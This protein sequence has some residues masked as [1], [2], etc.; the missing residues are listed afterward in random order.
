MHLSLAWLGVRLRP[1]LA[2]PV[3]HLTHGVVDKPFLG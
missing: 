2:P 1:V 3:Q